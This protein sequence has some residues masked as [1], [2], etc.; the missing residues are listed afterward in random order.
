MQNIK[1]IKIYQEQLLLGLTTVNKA[2]STKTVLPI[3]SNILLTFS[4]KKL[5]LFATDLEISIETTVNFEEGDDFQTTVPS[6]LFTNLISTMPSQLITLE[7]DDVKDNLKV[8][9]LKSKHNIKCI[10]SKDYPAKPA[11]IENKLFEIDTSSFKDSISRILFAA[12]EEDTKPV[13]SSIVFSIE[14]EKIVAYA[15]DGFRASL[16]TILLPTSLSETR[17]INIPS[18]AISEASKILN[19]D[20]IEFYSSENSIVLKSSVTSIFCQLIEGKA[21]DYTL[22]NTFVENINST[23]LKVN[24]V[25]LNLLCKQADLFV[26]QESSRNLK[27]EVDSSGLTISSASLQVGD[28]VG[29]INGVFQ[30]QPI[31]VVLSALYLR[32]F[33]EAVKL[34]YLTIKLKDGKSPVVFVLEEL[35]NY[36]HM[37]MPIVN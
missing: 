29:K 20:V 19:G 1:T 9:G 37:M 26:S 22:I 33:L 3:L 8:I 7:Y 13:L 24:T 6:T 4:N 31:R 27:L 30:G 25:E 21:P 36:F 14:D 32:E 12:S 35:P 11:D 23:I 18:Y 17:S 28:S 5:T 2:V 34:P 10:S 16:R 15:T